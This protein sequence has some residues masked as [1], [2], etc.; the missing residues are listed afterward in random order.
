LEVRSKGRIKGVAFGEEME[1]THTLF[2]DGVLF[3]GWGTIYE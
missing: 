1:I 3:F 2:V